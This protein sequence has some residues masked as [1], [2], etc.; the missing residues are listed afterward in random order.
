[1]LDREPKNK[2][3]HKIGIIRKID[4][5]LGDFDLSE[6]YLADR[7]DKQEILKGLAA[8]I[9]IQEITR[10][11]I[12][13]K[14]MNVDSMTGID[15]DHFVLYWNILAH[16]YRGGKYQRIFENGVEQIK[17]ISREETA[18]VIQQ[19]QYAIEPIL[20]D[21]MSQKTLSFGLNIPLLGKIG[22]GNLRFSATG[23]RVAVRKFQLRAL[24]L[25]AKWC[26][27]AATVLGAIH[28]V[29][30]TIF[31]SSFLA[32]QF[33]P[34]TSVVLLV[35]L[36]CGT[37]IAW[38][39]LKTEGLVVSRINSKIGVVSFKVFGWSVVGVGWL[40]WILWTL[41]DLPGKIEML[42]P[43]VKL[44]LPFY[45]ISGVFV[46]WIIGRISSN[47]FGDDALDTDS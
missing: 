37:I 47:Y 17:L 31:N 4:K 3:Q 9:I 40:Y 25:L 23:P 11:S 14:P 44:V 8:A 18:P 39:C 29:V 20:N 16:H 43:V 19:L 22:L 32:Y 15:Q 1:M 41:Y 46:G 36:F 24:R 28:W 10:M 35:L 33:E 7:D 27:W 34:V 30:W 38:L 2:E 21:E 26:I 12:T 6:E 13:K 45:I 42:V 5:I